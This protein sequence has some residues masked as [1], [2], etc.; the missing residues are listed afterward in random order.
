MVRALVRPRVLVSGCPTPRLLEEEVGELLGNDGG[1]VVYSSVRRAAARPPRWLA[2]R[3]CTPA[4]RGLRDTDNAV[5]GTGSTKIVAARI[6]PDGQRAFVFAS[7]DEDDVLE[8]LLHAHRER[9]ADVLAAW[10]REPLDHA[11]FHLG[12][13]RS[14]LVEST[15][16]CEGSRT[17]FY[18]DESFD[19]RFRAPEGVRKANLR[20]CDLRWC[21]RALRLPSRGLARR[22]P[23]PRPGRMAAPVPRDPRSMGNRKAERAVA[24]TGV[25]ITPRCATAGRSV[26]AGRDANDPTRRLRAPYHRDFPRAAIRTPQFVRPRRSPRA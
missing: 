9:A 16:A 11:A 15:I 2:W 21:T 24:R 23:R 25:G 19:D 12:S 8:Y 1:A 22:A 4:T 13:T 18:P 10:R 26:R 20:G 5:L 14:G 6:A 3:R 17:G 7:W